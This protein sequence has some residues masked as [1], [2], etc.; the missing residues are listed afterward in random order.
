MRAYLLTD[1]IQYEVCSACVFA[2]VCGVCVFVCVPTCSQTGHSMR[3]VHGVLAH[4]HVVCACVWCTCVYACLPT[5]WQDTVWGVWCVCVCMRAYLLTD[6]IQYEVCGACVFVCVPTSSQT[7]Y[8]MRCV[9]CVCLYVCVVCVCL[10]VCLPAHGQD[11]AVQT[12]ERWEGDE[13]RHDPRHDSEHL[14]RE[15]LQAQPM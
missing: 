4:W 1:R 6:R 7:G 10:Y 5:H 2:C 14:V 13:E 8:S 3:C 9:V 11:T 15:R 12:A